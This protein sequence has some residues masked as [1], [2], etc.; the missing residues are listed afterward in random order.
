MNR[1]L[2]AATMGTLLLTSVV[3]TAC[4]A[5]QVNQTSS[6]DRDKVGPSAEVGDLQLRQV[7]LVNPCESGDEEATAYEDGDDPELVLSIANGGADDTLTGIEGELFDG[8]YVG[9]PPTSGTGT[10]PGTGTTAGTGAAPT[11]GSTRPSSRIDV[12]VPA[13]EV[14]TIGLRQYAEGEP[15]D[16]EIDA[17]TPRLFLA[18]LSIEEPLTASQS[19]TL[20]FTFAEAGDVT[21]QAVVAGP[22]GDLER[23]EAFDFHEEEGAEG[24][25]EQDTEAE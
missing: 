21:V 12:P 7:Q 9:E 18:D 8:V 3:L 2:R 5:G 13:G 17:D 25:D 23:G 1:A 4:S 24:G 16:P 15:C 6:Q 22:Y 11:T 10:T 14:T 20:T 19:V